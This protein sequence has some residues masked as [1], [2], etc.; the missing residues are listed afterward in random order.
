MLIWLGGMAV[1]LAVSIALFVGERDRHMREVF[2]EGIAREVAAAVDVLDHLG[3]VQR[4][5][6]IDTLGRRRLRFMLAP[7]PPD[8][9]PIEAASPLA[10][11][12][13]MA[14]PE[15]DV[16]F[17]IRPLGG[18]D[19]PMHLQSMASLRLS[20]GTPLTIRM[21]GPMLGGPPRPPPPIGS[22][23]A[24][25]LA[26]V[27]GVSL[28]AWVAVRIATRP[29]S[30]L[31][32][33]ADALGADPNRPP[34]ATTGPAEV[35][36]AAHAFNRMQERLLQHV[37][38]RTR[39]LAA[40]SHDLQTP[41][42]RLRLRAELVD[43]EALRTKIQSDLDAMQALVKEGLDYARSLDARA[44]RQQIDLGAL[45]TA[46]RDD[47][48]DMGWD[49]T[50]PTQLAAACS[51]HP[52][53]LRRALWN[54]IENGVKFGEKVEIHTSETPDGFEIR[55]SD[56]GPGLPEEELEKVFEPFYRTEASRNRETGGTGLGLAIARNLLRSQG[57]DVRLA[58][59]PGGGLDAIVRLSGGT[60]HL[61]N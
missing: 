20:D 31:A 29:I 36:Q 49:V 23:L 22:L 15:R 37:T 17:L 10:D 35:E 55:V 6:W 56:A 2:S 59:R 57:G 45:L 27:L 4:E 47:A 9:R 19:H 44:A 43:D 26:L 34:L 50:V 5:D 52:V 16:A 21:A 54:L 61:T 18:E 13:R 3:S 30:R 42:T 32:A 33:A 28:L 60:R 39:I 7:P 38:E 25:L 41:I 53:G 12:L 11:A 46:L 14:M 58:S 1:V 51:G 8:A 48:Q 24:S 40:I